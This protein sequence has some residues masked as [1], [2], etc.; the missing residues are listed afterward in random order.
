MPI[1]EYNGHR[2][3]NAWNVTCWLEENHYNFIQKT[4]QKTLAKF[5]V[6]RAIGRVTYEVL[7]HLPKK[8]PDGAVYNTLSVKTYIEDQI[9]A[10]LSW[11]AEQASIK[12]NP[13]L[14]ARL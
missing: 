9:E 3:W 7:G 1:K 5:S 12:S 13:E 2:S 10:I 11:E 8:T 6:E 4:I 14:A